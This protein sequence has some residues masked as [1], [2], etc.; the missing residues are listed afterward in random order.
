MS[1]VS[2]PRLSGGLTASLLLHAGLVAGFVLLRPPA[3]PPSPPLYQVQL[4]AAPRGE[5]AVGAGVS[6]FARAAFG[7]GAG[8]A[9]FGVGLGFGDAV[10]TT[11][12]GGGA[13]IGGISGL[14]AVS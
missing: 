11:G 9:A 13:L 10:G 14:D 5:R 4:I 7:V 8:V 12:F 1:A 2:A 6:G 3:P